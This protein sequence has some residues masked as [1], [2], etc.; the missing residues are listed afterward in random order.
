MEDPGAA[1]EGL[2]QAILPDEDISLCCGAV[3]GLG[4][5]DDVLGAA[6][7]VADPDASDDGR[8]GRHLTVT[9]PVGSERNHSERCFIRS[10]CFWWTCNGRK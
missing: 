6:A 10:V 7:D 2:S 1:A 3:G 5:E 4:D 8:L 9:R